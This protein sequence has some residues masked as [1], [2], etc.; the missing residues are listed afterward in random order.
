MNGVA[1]CGGDLDQERMLG[2]HSHHRP[3]ASRAPYIREGCTLADNPSW[4]M[5][6]H[7]S[8]KLLN[9]LDPTVCKCKDV[10]MTNDHMEPKT[11]LVTLI[12]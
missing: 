9:Y 12:I 8:A 11:H 1:I 2:R 6:M 5:Q 4:T 10:Q 7:G 3:L